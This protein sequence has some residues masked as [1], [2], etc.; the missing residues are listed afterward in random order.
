MVRRMGHLFMSVHRV[1]DVS[2]HRD[3]ESLGAACAGVRVMPS[4]HA[5][6]RCRASTAWVRKAACM[7]HTLLSTAE[8]RAAREARRASTRSICMRKASSQLLR[9]ADTRLRCTSSAA[10]APVASAV[11]MNSGRVVTAWRCISL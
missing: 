7:D 10:R 1:S 8:N 6:L 4:L 2:S 11:T 3:N 5:S 9:M